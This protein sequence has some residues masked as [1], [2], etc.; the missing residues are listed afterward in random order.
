MEHETS[1]LFRSLC[2]AQV[3]DNPDAA[4][5]LALLKAYGPS[6]PPALLKRVGALFAELRSMSGQSCAPFE[7]APSA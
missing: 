2:A 3:L 6:V 5:E 7:L 4:S 1:A